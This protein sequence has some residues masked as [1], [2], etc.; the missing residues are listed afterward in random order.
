MGANAEVGSGKHHAM[1]I[2]EEMRAATEWGSHMP[3][4]LACVAAS[5]GPVLELGVGHFSTPQLHAICATMGRYLLSVESNDDWFTQ[6]ANIYETDE[7]GFLTGI[8]DGVD[9]LYFGVAFIDHSPGGANRA[10]AFRKLI[11]VSGYVVV[12]DAQQ[13]AENFQHIEPMLKGLEWHLCTGYFPHTLVAS[14]KYALPK[15]L[16]KM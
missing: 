4:L 14:K 3:A 13:N 6:M 16:L 11:E 5:T 1:T 12:H 2:T 10:D 8:P 15:V 7:H 9:Q